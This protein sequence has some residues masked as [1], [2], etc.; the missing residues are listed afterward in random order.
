VARP[1]RHR[2]GGLH[3]GPGGLTT[4]SI[5]GTNRYATSVEVSKRAFPTGAN[6]VVIATGENW[7]DALGG[8]ALAGALGGPILLTRKTALPSE[9]AAEIG[10][11]K[12]KGAV[13]LG[14]TAAVSAGVENA[15]KAMFGAD[16]VTRI[17]GANRTRQ[18]G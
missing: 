12:P 4:T 15:L 6:A 13:I 16:Y 2:L 14:S 3:R 18:R 8:S 9:V 11:L 10:R 17:G 7:P 5:A 1:R